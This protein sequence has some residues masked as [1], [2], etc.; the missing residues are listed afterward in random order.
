LRNAM[1]ATI[2]EARPADAASIARVHVD[3]WRTTYRGIVPDEHLDALSYQQRET[4]WARILAAP[5]M[6]TQAVFVTEDEGG[7]IIG[8]ANGG[9]E[10]SHDPV[11]TGE[12]YAIYLLDKCHGQGMGRRLTRSVADWL[13][14][15]GMTSMLV[16][17]AARNPA[18]YFY[19][20]LGGQHIRTKEEMIGGAIIEEIAY[21]WTDTS[22]LIRDS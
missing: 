17:V 6:R 7:R 8:F 16:W 3:I 11:Y 13:A 15:K 5:G 22:T 18:R 2:R 4:M 10:R 9:P 14:G 12:L 21:G 20:A 19:E 1:N